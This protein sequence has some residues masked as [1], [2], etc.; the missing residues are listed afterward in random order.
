MR[1]FIRL[2]AICAAQK[3]FYFCDTEV[4]RGRDDVEGAPQPQQLV[5]QRPLRVTLGVVRVPFKEAHALRLLR[6]PPGQVMLT[7]QTNVHGGLE[8]YVLQT[9]EL[10]H[11]SMYGR[12]GTKHTH[13]DV[14]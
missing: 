5:V 7:R 3:G 6:T 10:D 2:H 4:D 12:S 9:C 13:T 14:D 1:G 8:R 11:R